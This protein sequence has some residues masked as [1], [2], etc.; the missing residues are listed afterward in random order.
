MNPNTILNNN[1]KEELKKENKEKDKS[2]EEIS[3]KEEIKMLELVKYPCGN[4]CLP[5]PWISWL[6]D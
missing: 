4:V 6:I 3:P 5:A 2:D 1:A